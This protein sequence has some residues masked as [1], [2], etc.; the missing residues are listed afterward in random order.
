M[1]WKV[2]TEYGVA[3]AETIDELPDL[4]EDFVVSENYLKLPDG[5][6]ADSIEDRFLKEIMT[7]QVSFADQIFE[8]VES[9][10]GLNEGL[11][12][13]AESVEL[14]LEN[15]VF[16]LQNQKDFVNRSDLP[17]PEKRRQ[18]EEIQEN[19][20]SVKNQLEDLKRFKN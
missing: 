19:L 16:V 10:D 12:V 5:K 14:S 17:K 8:N 15:Q 9:I 1:T 2:E 11:R 3:I 18:I 7:F 4:D 13:L 6:L 20:V